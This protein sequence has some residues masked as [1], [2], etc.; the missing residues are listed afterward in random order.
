MSRTL[1]VS[2]SAGLFIGHANPARADLAENLASAAMTSLAE[3]KG[4]VPGSIGK[5]GGYALTAFGISKDVSAGKPIGETL[6]RAGGQEAGARIGIREAIASV[7]L[8]CKNGRL[9]SCAVGVTGGAITL[10]G[11]TYAGG[12]LAAAADRRARQF[13]AQQTLKKDSA[14][15]RTTDAPCIDYYTVGESKGCNEAAA[16]KP[17]DEA[18]SL[19]GRWSPPNGNC[20]DPVMITQT[21][22]R[23]FGAGTATGMCQMSKLMPVSYPSAWQQQVSC[24]GIVQNISY[25][26]AARGP[27]QLS[28]RICGSASCGDAGTMQRCK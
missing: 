14:N 22:I 18:S 20:Q 24:A 23:G 8:G 10:V 5:Y 25:Q 13:D 1:L 15:R 2:I 6:A 4:A 21:E 19:I 27:D 9:A 26:F 16:P 11:A 7:E 28:V 12:E 17:P 3:V